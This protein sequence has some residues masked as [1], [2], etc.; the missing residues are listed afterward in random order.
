[1][2]ELAAELSSR[3][4][5]PRPLG[6]V[7]GERYALR[8]VLGR[9]AAAVVYAAEHVR[10]RRPVAL[11]LPLTDPELCEMLSA[12]LR[13]ETDALARVRHPAVVDVID[14]GESE[15]LPFLAM[16]LLEGRTLSGLIAARGRLQADEAVKVGIALAD[17]LAAVHASGF[18]HRDVK[19]ANVLVTRS[20]ADQVHLCDFGVARA[21]T[22]AALAGAK[23]TQTGAIVG[24]PEYMAMEALIA[25]DEADHRVDVYAVGVLLFEC[26]TGAVPFEGSLAQILQ[27]LTSARPPRVS[28]VR[29]DVPAALSALVA[30]CLEHDPAARFASM[31]EVAAALRACIP[32]SPRPIDLL[33]AEPEAEPAAAVAVADPTRPSFTARREHARA[34]Y[35][36]VS[37]LQREGE[38]ARTARIEDISEGGVLLISEH[39]YTPGEIVR[40]RFSPPIS[41]RVITLPATVRWTRKARTG[42][43]TGLGFTELPDAARAEIRQYVALMGNP[44]DLASRSRTA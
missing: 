5:D 3:E 38:P 20:P 25:S 13:R 40:L 8:R 19:P 30:R 44:R 23:L 10:V 24:T 32:G 22:P 37:S 39:A 36:T 7:V 27:R 6:A 16:E 34:P 26:L 9:G 31:V 12:R 4:S 33:R 43:A 17:G 42:P 14:A 11:K 15:G 41:G 18:A 29:P 2:S 21:L 1:M 35:M 28:D